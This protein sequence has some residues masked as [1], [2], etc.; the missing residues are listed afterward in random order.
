MDHFNL[1]DGI[2]HA[3]DVPLPAIADAVGTP[4]Y[5]YS[6][7]T[8]ARHVDVFK[9]ALADVESGSEGPLIAFAVKA[10]PN[11]AV[12]ATMAAMGLGADVVSGG[13]LLRARAAGIPAERIVFS[14]VGKTAAEMRT[15]LEQGIFQ[16]NVESEP[17]A[18][19]LSEVAAAMGK[20][21]PVAFRINPNVIAGTHAKISTGGSEDKFGVAYDRALAAYARAAS[22]PGLDVRGIAVHIGSQ[23]TD[24]APSRAAFEKIGALIAELRAAGHGITTADLGGGLGV[25]YDPAKPIP[26]LPAAYG[27]MVAEVTKG[28]N[29]RLVFEPGRVIVGNAGVLLT[30]VIRVKPGVT[31]PFVIVDAAMNDLMRPSLYDAWHD[32]VQVSPNGASM[33]ANVVG[34]ICESGDT[35]AKKRVMDAVAPGDLVVFKTAGAYGATMANSYNTRALTPEVMVNGDQWAVV[36]ERQPIEALIAADKLPPWI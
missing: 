6:A 30:E 26:P 27:A 2:L 31:D 29:V 24:L 32:I 15:G 10:N 7:A 14:G 23:L 22:L 33:T 4:V 35:F 3:E 16:F 9:A 1:K 12:L 28:W 20:K 34:P 36:R 5:V 17:E 13:E 18:D 11:R 8:I 25:P 21:A 19:M